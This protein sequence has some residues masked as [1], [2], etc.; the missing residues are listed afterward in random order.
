MQNP[1]VGMIFFLTI[2]LKLVFGFEPAIASI[3]NPDIN[4]INGSVGDKKIHLFP[5]NDIRDHRNMQWA[6]DNVTPGGTVELGAGTFFLGDGNEAPRKTVTVRQGLKVIGVKEGAIWRTI[7]RGGGELLEDWDWGGEM[8]IYGSIRINVEGDERPVII[9]DVWFRD[10]LSETIFIYASSGFEFR[11]CRITDG[12]TITDPAK[13]P[14]IHALSSRG[15]NARGNF[16]VENNIVELG[17]YDGVVPEDEQFVGT[18]ASNH[19][20]I[21]IVNNSIVGIDEGIEILVNGYGDTGSD[22]PL[23][24]GSPSEIVVANNRIDVTGTPG[25]RWNHSFAILIA[26]NLNVDKV[27]VE[28]NHVTKRGEGWGMGLSGA[29]FHVTGNTFRFEEHN[30]K[31]TLGAI[32]LGGFP[33][34]GGRDLG[35]SLTNSVIENNTFEGKVSTYGIYFRPDGKGLINGSEGFVNTS[36]GNMIDL[37]KSLVTL[38]AKETLTLS[39]KITNNI[40]KGSTGRVIDNRGK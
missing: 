25:L 38:G 17:Q 6:F 15:N 12:V 36:S 24:S 31:L 9:E 2:F 13:I 39:P 16:I 3:E 33:R 19:D 14:G 28:N 34:L 30:S 1:Q 37:G 23:E 8:E 5:R 10:W 40:F 20:K 27:L 29:N 22:D 35:A 32:S 11:N 18:Y 7:I 21:Q 4:Y 26:G